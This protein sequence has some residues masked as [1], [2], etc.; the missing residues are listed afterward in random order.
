MAET[1]I[2]PFD[3][4]FIFGLSHSIFYSSAHINTILI[5]NEKI[6]FIVFH[7]HLLNMW[8]IPVL[9]FGVIL[10]KPY[11]PI[12]TFVKLKFPPVYIFS[13]LILLISTFPNFYPFHVLRQKMP[14]LTLHRCGKN[15]TGKGYIIHLMY[16][17]NVYYYTLIFCV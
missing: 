12:H 10:I 4:T 3:S 17:S 6:F 15:I 8:H 7:K 1:Q 16:N 11:E 9:S 13:S 5:E 14:L 2:H